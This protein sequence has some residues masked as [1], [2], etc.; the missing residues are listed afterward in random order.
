MK[1][2]QSEILK[3]SSCAILMAT[4]LSSP[5]SAKKSHASESN[6]LN[7]FDEGLNKTIA[8]SEKATKLAGKPEAA[9]DQEAIAEEAV[10]QAI[11]A[12]E[13]AEALQALTESKGKDSSSSKI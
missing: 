8:A 7:T 4:F 9:V 5:V 2:T 11:A 10:L 3:I 13:R 6:A 12:A 1:F